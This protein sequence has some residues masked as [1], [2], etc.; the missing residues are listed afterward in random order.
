[1]KMKSFR[2]LVCLVV[3][4]LS[5]IAVAQTDAVAEQMQWFKDAKFGMFIHFDVHRSDGG[6]WN[7]SNLDAKEWV[8]IA[9][10]AGMKYMVPT[11]HQSSYIIMW[12]SKVSTRD[13]TELTPFR[14]DYLKELSEACKAEGLRM[15]AYYAI[16]DPGNPLYN[17]PGVGGEIKPYVEYLHAVIKELCEKYEPCLLWFDASRRFNHPVEK[18][19]LR[20]G[21][22]VEMLNS[23][24]CISNSRLGDDDAQR[25]VNYLTMNDKMAPDL[26]LGVYWESAVTLG[27][28]WH[29]RANEELKTPKELLHRLINAAGNGGN[30][31]LNV[32]PDED[33]VIPK[34][35]ADRL[36]IMGQWLE[37][38]GEA[39]YGTQ[40]GPYPYQISWGSITQREEEGNTNLYLNVVDWPETGEFT[41]FG[42]KN[43]VLN[44]SLLATGEAI[45]FKSEFDASSGQNTITLDIPKNEPDDYVS[46]IKLVIAGDAVMDQ[47]HLQLTDGKVLLDT[48][49]A[50]IHDL[51][52]VPEKPTKAIDMKM[53]TVAE[54]RPM[55]PSDHTEPWESDYSRPWD[56]Q[57]YKKPGEGIMPARGITVSGF[58]TKGQA[59]SWDFKVYEPGRF[60]VVVVC[61]VTK[62]SNWDVGGSVRAHV[63]GQTV[64]NQL[65]ESKRAET[66]T[67]PKHVELHSVLGAV[68]IDSAGAHTL[69]LEIAENLTGGKPNFQRVMLIPTNNQEE[70]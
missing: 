11:T 64:E 46:V 35:Y 10:E 2:L 24:G 60:N 66:I 56:Y 54:R 22:M 23:Y 67:V 33:G 59:L 45:G 8:R 57:T 21:D 48:Y 17:E 39:I 61:H 29:F 63:A 16:A 49:N 36:K 37:R 53:F 55:L 62:G 52:F 68:E 3:L 7:P 50:N 4:M 70:K 38:N 26:N 27:E 20:Q 34:Y 13:V 19:L 41:L 28:S 25:Y 15:G 18:R 12:D 44:A 6:N 31:L 51:E 14:Q 69:T 5:G 65:I 47:D 40:A 42:L 1:M 9:K 30:L 58:Q 32:G 43:K